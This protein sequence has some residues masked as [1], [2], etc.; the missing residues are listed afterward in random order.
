MILEFFTLN[1]DNKFPAQ[2]Q[3]DFVQESVEN[4]DLLAQLRRTLRV[5]DYSSW[6]K[7]LLLDGSSPTWR[8]VSIHADLQMGS[9]G[10][11][12]AFSVGCPLPA[13][14]LLSTLPKCLHFIP[15]FISWRHWPSSLC[16]ILWIK[17]GGGEEEE[18][19]SVL[20]ARYSPY[21]EKGAGR[22]CA[23]IRLCHLYVCRRRHGPSK[24]TAGVFPTVCSLGNYVM[25]TDNQWLLCFSKSLVNEACRFL[26][27]A[28]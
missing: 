5:E 10:W 23:Y 2:I 21:E 25:F 14:F 19:A 7:L 17:A 13:S 18:A 20:L 11:S 3:C 9:L 1:L 6:R 27:V 26:M 8:A 22:E 12:N 16:P 24:V 4:V 15:A 28:G